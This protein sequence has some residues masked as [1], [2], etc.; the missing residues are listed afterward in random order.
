MKKQHV[1]L[2]G[3]DRATLITLME[4]G[5]LGVKQCKRALGLLELDRGKTLQAVAI[6]L[7]VNHNTVAGWRDKYQQHG[8]VFLPDQPRCGRPVV[9]DGRQRAKLTALACSEAPAGHAQW[10]L[11]LLAEKAVEL[12]YCTQISHTQVRKILKKTR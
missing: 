4:Q 1:Q 2:S 7:D 12:G 6:T 10:N 3:T 8:L 11:R 5:T 9:I